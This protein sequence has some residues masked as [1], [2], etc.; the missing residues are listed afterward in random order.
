[1]QDAKERCRCKEIEGCVKFLDNFSEDSMLQGEQDELT[2]TIDHPGF[3]AICLLLNRWSLELAA[4]NFKT[5]DGHRY[6]QSGSKEKYIIYLHT[7]IINSNYP[8]LALCHVVGDYSPPDE[9]E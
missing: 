2:C 7:A 9:F 4:D 6:K 1:L 3:P 8:D 5:R